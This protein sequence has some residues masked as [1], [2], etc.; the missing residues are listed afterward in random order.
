MSDKIMSIFAYCLAFFLVYG[1]FAFILISKVLQCFISVHT[2]IV[3]Y[4][5]IY[6][7]TYCFSF[8]CFYIYCNYKH[9]MKTASHVAYLSMI[10]SLTSLG[11]S[12]EKLLEE[13][14]LLTQEVAYTMNTSK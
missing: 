7:D 12:I 6:G 5:P 3:I 4:F 14:R 1:I 11:E 9:L 2:N 8:L 10:V 13:K